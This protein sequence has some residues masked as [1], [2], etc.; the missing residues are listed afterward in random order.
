MGYTITVK[1]KEG[2][3][4]ANLE[5]IGYAEAVVTMVKIGI[6]FEKEIANGIISVELKKQDA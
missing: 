6:D 2:E 5:N 4:V 1:G 3:P